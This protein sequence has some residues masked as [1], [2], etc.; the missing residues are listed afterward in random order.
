M[1]RTLT[2][3]ARVLQQELDGTAC[4]D[5]SKMEGI[6]VGKVQKPPRDMDYQFKS[7]GGIV[8]GDVGPSRL[9]GVSV[10]FQG[11]VVRS[12]PGGFCQFSSELG[13][14]VET[15][16]VPDLTVEVW[17]RRTVDAFN[18]RETLV[19]IDSE[20]KSQENAISVFLTPKGEVNV[21]LS[22][23][24]RTVGPCPVGAIRDLEWHHVAV[25]RTADPS[26]VNN[27]T[28]YVDGSAVWSTRHESVPIAHASATIL[29][30][31]QH[32]EGWGRL[33]AWRPGIGDKTCFQGNLCHFAFHYKALDEHQMAARFAGTNMPALDQDVL[34]TISANVGRRAMAA[35][36]K[37]QRAEVRVS[38]RLVLCFYVACTPQP[39]HALRTLFLR[40]EVSG[41]E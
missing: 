7:A 11:G 41:A 3:G 1:L 19:S 32:G 18:Q 24:T 30:G 37:S 34:S 31:K 21:A 5:R 12:R 22:G 28:F 16:P 25:S 40:S 15:H 14:N 8:K 13:A 17:L 39:V 23:C 38:H 6:E 27:W 4:K 29:L 9:G 2:L 26:V 36:S 33:R 20:A 10:C 35:A